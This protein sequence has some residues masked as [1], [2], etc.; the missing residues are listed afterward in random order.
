M[1]SATKLATRLFGTKHDKDRKRLEPLIGEINEAFEG[2][3]G[4]SDDDLRAR[5]A[6]WQGEFKAIW[7]DPELSPEEQEAAVKEHL[8]SIL[9]EAFAV[10]KDA[11]RRQ[12]GKSWPVVGIETRWEMIPYNVQLLGG[13]VLHEGKIAEM[14]TGEGKTLVAVLPL[15]LNALPGKGCHLVTVNDYLARRD[16]EWV[17]SVLKFLGL[18]VGVIQHDQSPDVRRAQYDADVTYGTN[19]E[20][21]FDYLRDNMAVRMEDRV[22]RGFWYTIV[23]EVDSV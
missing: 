14:A 12:V 2:L 7:N 20:F 19:N 3:A 1:G 9:P 16:A 8:E 4:L 6:T 21:G 18:T 17:G 22:Q 13:I 5:T 15:Y 10:V 23:D 11:C